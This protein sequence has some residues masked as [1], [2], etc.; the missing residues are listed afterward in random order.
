[1]RQ[2]PYRSISLHP[3]KSF[4]SDSFQ[5]NSGKGWKSLGERHVRYRAGITR[6]HASKRPF[7]F[8]VDYFVLG[9]D[10]C[11]VLRYH[12]SLFLLQLDP[13]PVI[14]HVLSSHSKQTLLWNCYAISWTGIA[15]SVGLQAG[16]RIQAGGEVMFLL[17]QTGGRLPC[18]QPRVLFNANRIYFCGL[19]WPEFED[20]HSRVS[21]TVF[22]NEGIYTAISIYIFIAFV[23]LTSF[24]ML[25]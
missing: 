5:P 20:V 23:G 19:K 13:V 16:F 9:C 7:F 18:A 6:L 22:S 1:M 14:F 25:S 10:C 15:Q 24:F 17:L 12:L 11:V 21:S 8:L 3:Q 2:Y 4:R